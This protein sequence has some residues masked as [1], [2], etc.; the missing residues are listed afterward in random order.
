MY[1]KYHS[2]LRKSGL[3][4]GIPLALVERAM[5]E[6]ELFITAYRK[7]DII[8]TEGNPL[9]QCGFMLSGEAAYVKYTASGDRTLVEHIG[10]GRLFGEVLLFSTAPKLWPATLVARTDCAVLFIPAEWMLG[11]K[12]LP[13]LPYHQMMANTLEAICD[14]TVSLFDFLGCFKTRTIRGKISS[15]LYQ[16][17]LAGKSTVIE[18]P[19]DRDEWADLLFVPRPSLSRELSNMKKDGLIDYYKSSIHILNIR[20]LQLQG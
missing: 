5:Q 14:R 3:F 1:E 17:Y 12:T 15:Y 18:L 20:G 16:Q 8:V 9:A 10:A 13:Y 2:V 11:Q 19:F 4:R 6:M 7:R